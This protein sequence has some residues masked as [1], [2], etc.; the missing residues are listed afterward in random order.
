MSNNDPAPQEPSTEIQSTTGKRIV[1]LFQ[2]AL[3]LFADLSW[4]RR[5][6]DL[7]AFRIRT[8]L[9]RVRPDY[10]RPYKVCRNCNHPKACHFPADPHCPSCSLGN[11]C[12]QFVE[13]P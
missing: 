12:P 8:F 4:H 9:K 3:N 5:E 6:Q 13:K 1:V 2:E 10:F 7:L 11:A